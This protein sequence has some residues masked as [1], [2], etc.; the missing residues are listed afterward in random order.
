M[1]YSR[2]GIFVAK[3][4][5]ELGNKMLF[6]Q[7]IFRLTNTKKHNNNLRYVTGNECK[8]HRQGGDSSVAYDDPIWLEIA[9]I[10]LEGGGIH[11]DKH[12]SLVAGGVHILT[13]THLIARHSAQRTLGRADLCRIIRERGDLVSFSGGNVGKDISRKLHAVA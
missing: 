12:I 2:W 10:G 13:H 11:R 6:C 3:I 1:L 7:T 4:F 9:E 8:D 5:V